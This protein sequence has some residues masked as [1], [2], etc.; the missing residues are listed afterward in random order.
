MGDFYSQGNSKRLKQKELSHQPTPEHRDEKKQ[1]AHFLPPVR[2]QEHSHSIMLAENPRLIVVQRPLPHKCFLMEN[3]PPAPMHPFML[4]ITEAKRVFL[5]TC[6]AY[7]LVALLFQSAFA[8]LS[9]YIMHQFSDSHS[10]PL[11]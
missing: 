11:P 2:E 3:L 9:E 4:V 1:I 8:I 5:S 7:F 10:M 6:S